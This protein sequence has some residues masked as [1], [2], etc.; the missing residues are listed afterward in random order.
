MYTQYG[1]NLDV[2]REL[3]RDE[4]V[5]LIHLDPPFDSNATCCVL[6]KAHAGK[7]CRAQIATFGDKWPSGPQGDA[8]NDELTKG[9][10]PI[11]VARFIIEAMRS[12]MKRAYLLVVARNQLGNLG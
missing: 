6:F 2:L 9:R 8:G 10:A 12:S 1:D 3:V 4:S 11:D 7:G 5:D